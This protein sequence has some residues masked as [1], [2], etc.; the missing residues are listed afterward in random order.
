M[1]VKKIVEDFHN[2]RS[3]SIM[4][5][6]LIVIEGTDCSGKE[7]Q[8]RLLAKK[9]NES[10]I[11]SQHLS[12]PNYNKPTGKIIGSCYLGREELCRDLLKESNSWFEEGA[13]NVDGLVSSLY[14]AADRRYNIK[15]IEDLLNKGVNVILDRYTFSNMAHQG[16]KIITQEER[17]QFFKKIEV[18]EFDLLGLPKPDLVILLYVPYQVTIELQESRNETRDQHEKDKNHLK[19]AE[20]TYLELRALYHFKMIECTKE[21]KIRTIEEIHQ[22]LFE[23]IKQV[24][25]GREKD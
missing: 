24:I 20:Q 21:G 10:G 3:S 14:Y 9:L 6:K 13:S 17:F 1:M 12:F 11:K 5:G 22:E 16:G 25:E 2:R 8:A 19:R 7:T 4:R 23:N 18:L 15:Q